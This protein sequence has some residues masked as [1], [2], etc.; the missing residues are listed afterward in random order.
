[1][2]SPELSLEIGR[3]QGQVEMLTLLLIIVLL[4]NAGVILWLVLRRS[5][6]HPA[7][8]NSTISEATT[9]LDDDQT[10]IVQQAELLLL[11]GL[12]PP[13]GFLQALHKLK[14]YGDGYNHL[15][16]RFLDARWRREVSIADT[17]S[18]DLLKR[19]N[20]KGAHPW[21]NLMIADIAAFR[22]Q[23]DLATERLRLTLE[24]RDREAPIWQR[25]G[26]AHLMHDEADHA[27]DC[28][29]KA[30]EL[31]MKLSNAWLQMGWAELLAHRPDMVDN[32]L[33]F[34]YDFAEP[35]E[36]QQ[37]QRRANMV[38]TLGK[39]A[40]GYEG[41]AVTLLDVLLDLHRNKETACEML[42]SLEKVAPLYP[43]QV[44]VFLRLRSMLLKH[45]EQQGFSHES[46][47]S[48]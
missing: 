25:M 39:A 1:M 15:L 3:M 32:H 41:E 4:I 13:P 19:F 34:A 2:N 17:L 33:K 5:T 48:N 21:I 31:E 38:S 45:M 11:R 43:D 36:E 23:A 14:D 44:P 47:K 7:T 20:E 22:Q 12:N 24:Q 10:D 6:E 30:V 18:D 46:M 35:G 16:Y 37:V 42:K 29:Q 26:E 40:L 28:L 27:I 8:T 9:I